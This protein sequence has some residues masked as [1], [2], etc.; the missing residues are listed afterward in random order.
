MITA[1][2]AVDRIVEDIETIKGVKNEWRF[3]D[4]WEVDKIKERW[5]KFVEEVNK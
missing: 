4:G 5:V 3:L 1:A 2:D